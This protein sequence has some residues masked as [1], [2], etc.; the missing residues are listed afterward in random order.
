VLTLGFSPCPNDTFVFHALVHGLVG[1][2]AFAPP[3]YA[4]I[5]V[6]NARAL[7]DDLDVVKV[8]YGVLPHLSGYTLL[9]SGGALGRGCGPLVLTRSPDVDLRGATIAIPGEQT[10]A[11]LLLRL[12]DPDYGAV[13]VMPFDRIMPAVRDGEVDAG[14]VIH[15]S[16]FTYP[17]YGLHCAAD[18]GDWWER[19]TGLPVPL[20][21]IVA[22][23]GLDMVAIESAIRSSVEY[24]WAHPE[25]SRAYVLAHSQELAPEVVDA[26]IAL[27]V[28]EF[29][30]D[31]GDEGRRA[32]KELLARA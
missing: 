17:S 29:T 24:A 28:N 10:T 20:G 14:L 4:D 8:S 9:S 11:Y 22:R 2:P 15:E 19:E 18:L 16:R 32:I 23:D 27:Y 7:A 5:D 3:V 12:W 30:R 13:V 25:A 21:A 31:L 6:L 1:G 26:H